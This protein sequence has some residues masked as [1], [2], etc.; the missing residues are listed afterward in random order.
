M[1]LSKLTQDISVTGQL[2]PKDMAL[3]KSLGF[4]SVICN[5]PD[6]ESADQPLFESISSAGALLD[7]ETHYLP[8]SSGSQVPEQVHALKEL[9]PE[10]PKPVLFY[11][12]SGARSAALVDAAL[13]TGLV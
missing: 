3:V 9:W 10:L 4:A 8:I 1:D 7:L 5:R 2:T 11:C 6:G 12:R 13:T